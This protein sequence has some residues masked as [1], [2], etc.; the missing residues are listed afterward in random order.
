MGADHCKFLI[1][2]ADRV[3]AAAFWRSQGATG[4]DIMKKVKEV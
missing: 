4:K 2:H 1:S 3:D